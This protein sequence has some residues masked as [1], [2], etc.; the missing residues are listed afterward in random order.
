MIY[1][2]KPRHSQRLSKQSYTKWCIFW[3]TLLGIVL[4]FTIFVHSGLMDS[5]ANGDGDSVG[6]IFVPPLRTAISGVLG[7]MIA[8]LIPPQKLSK[9]P[10]LTYYGL[11]LIV[12][13][14]IY[15]LF[16]TLETSLLGRLFFVTA[17]GYR[18]KERNGL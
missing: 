4:S 15:M 9:K 11:A 17:Q 10:F 6:I 18:Q 14:F 1:D 5:Y 16:I 7:L 8:Q 2:E 12:C 13:F 3:S